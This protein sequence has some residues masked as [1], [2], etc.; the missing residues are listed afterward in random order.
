MFYEK[1]EKEFFD[2]VFHFN[3]S[4]NEVSAYFR[5]Y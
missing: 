3:D 1:I 4:P 2:E 5:R